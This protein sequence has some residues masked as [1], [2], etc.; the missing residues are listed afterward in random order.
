[1]AAVAA[2][3]E[4]DILM[5]FWELMLYIIRVLFVPVAL[6]VVNQGYGVKAVVYVA[7]TGEVMAL[8][9][10]FWLL[11]KKLDLDASYL[12]KMFFSG[13]I[14]LAIPVAYECLYPAQAFAIINWFGLLL[15]V[16][17]IIYMLQ[18]PNLRTMG[19]K[20]LKDRKPGSV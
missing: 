7:I 1:M 5:T 12:V 17:T 2:K 19:L 6:F 8:L 4:H 14:A 15:V 13:A 18:L 16:V 10:S 20:Y 9:A 11:V 3:R